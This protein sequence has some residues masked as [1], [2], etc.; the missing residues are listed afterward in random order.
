MIEMRVYHFLSTTYGVN[1]IALKRLKVSR[2]S[3]LNDPYELLAADTTDPRDREALDRFKAQIDQTK[4][5]IC[6][7]N[8]W[9]NPLLWG[10]YADKHKGMALGFDIPDHLIIK[11]RYT[12][13]RAK[14]NFD[15][16]TH[17]IIDGTRVLGKLIR[18]KFIDW[19]Y[20]EEMRMYVDLTQPSE[21]GNYYVDFSN[22]LVLTEVILGVK[23]E[24]PL[25]RVNQLLG[26]SAGS[27][28]VK[29]ARMATKTFK[30][31]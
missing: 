24:F 16:K 13:N 1:D 10:H 18:T 4:G 31:I 27:V 12:T 26:A 2:F 20:E 21:D 15:P 29:N 8:T 3:Q 25:A 17:R 5:M 7:S 11:V 14:I 19:R 23:C 30:V 22:E 6:F 28:K 9:T